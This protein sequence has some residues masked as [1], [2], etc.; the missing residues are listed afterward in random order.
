MRRPTVTLAGAL[1]VLAMLSAAAVAAR[2]VTVRGYIANVT[3]RSNTGAIQSAQTDDWPQ[4]QHD[5]QRT[6]Y[7]PLSIQPPFKLAWYR[8][9]QP[10]RV[11]RDVQAVICAGQVYVPTMA[12][13]LY[14]LD[15]S[16]GAELWVYPVGSPV[17]HTAACTGDRVVVAAIDGSVHA[18]S[19]ADGQSLWVFRARGHTG[20]SAAPLIAESM[21]YIGERSGLFYAIDLTSGEERWAFDASAPIF[22]TAAYDAGRV[23]FCDESLRVHALDAQSGSQ[24]WVSEQLYGQSCKQYHPVVYQG[25]V[26]IRPMM[27]HRIG[28]IDGIPPFNRTWDSATYQARLAQYAGVINGQPLSQDLLDAQ[29]DILNYYTNNPHEQSLFVLNASDGQQ[30]FIPPHFHHMTLPGPPPPPVVDGL[31]GGVIIPWTFIGYGWG[32][33]DLQQRRVTY[34]VIPPGDGGN[35]DESVN[36]SMGGPLWFMFHAQEGNAQYTGIF[37]WTDGQFYTFSNSQVP[38]RNWQLTD[39]ANNGN[40]SVSV[41][42]GHF[43]HITFHQLAAWTSQ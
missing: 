39:N 8:N 28:I 4:L 42:S 25:Y 22:N 5:P 20:F 16:T 38:K 9:F 31:H 17:L 7:A 23:F 6:G 18:V 1:L 40:N 12:G 27:T 33:L 35:H 30:A 14:A 32:H 29:Q 24:L 11:G 13:N 34:V 10:E 19:A 37:D 3:T 21:V 2:F 15:A 36:V 41:A 43:F 26:L